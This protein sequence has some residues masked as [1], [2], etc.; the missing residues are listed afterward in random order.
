[1]EDDGVVVLGDFC[2]CYH[3]YFPSIPSDMPVK[4]FLVEF[5]VWED[6]C[7]SAGGVVWWAAGG[8]MF[9]FGSFY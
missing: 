3:G 2:D 4:L 7:D 1:M 8:A 9:P 5:V 6:V